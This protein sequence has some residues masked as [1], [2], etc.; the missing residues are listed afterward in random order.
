MKSD[1]KFSAKRTSAALLFVLLSQPI[2]FA[3]DP[4]NYSQHAAKLS[5]AAVLT[6][7]RVVKN[8]ADRFTQFESQKQV[9]IA[10]RSMK[11]LERQQAKWEKMSDEAFAEEQNRKIKMVRD[12]QS[13]KSDTTPSETIDSEDMLSQDELSLLKN[14]NTQTTQ[15]AL[16]EVSIPASSRTTALKNVAQQIQTLQSFIQQGKAATQNHAQYY[17]SSTDT[18]VVV[19]LAILIALAITMTI[20][21]IVSVVGIPV[22]ATFITIGVLSVCGVVYNFEFYI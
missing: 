19:V 13:L 1:Q 6:V 7:K 5:P 9:R 21:L 2:A 10:E 17:D 15:T 18:W 3:Y 22:A 20:L 16:P 14:D 8:Y 4:V 11:R 12:L